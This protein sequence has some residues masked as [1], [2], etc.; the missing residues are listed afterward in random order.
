MFL[1]FSSSI[2]ET[3]QYEKSWVHFHV[4]V[5]IGFNL[6]SFGHPWFYVLLTVQD[7]PVSQQISNRNFVRFMSTL[8]PL[9]LKIYPLQ[10]SRL[11]EL[12]FSFFGGWESLYFLSVDPGWP[13]HNIAVLMVE[14]PNGK[15]LKKGDTQFTKTIHS[16]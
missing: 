13:L 4:W 14:K 8:K 7:T 10:I 6:F 15:L 1:L 3:V 16:N 12:R 9:W 11:E 2:E 5:L